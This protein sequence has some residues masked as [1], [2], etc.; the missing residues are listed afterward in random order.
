MIE[1]LALFYGQMNPFLAME[2]LV[3]QLCTDFR[4]YYQ[5]H[6]T[7]ELLEMT[8]NYTT[9]KRPPHTANLLKAKV[10]Q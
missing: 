10:G 6:T 8:Q 1:I 2:E 7:G 5:Q 4:F 3:T 9:A